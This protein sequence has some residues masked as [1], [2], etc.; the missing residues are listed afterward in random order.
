M[1]HAQW[2]NRQYEFYYQTLDIHYRERRNVRLIMKRMYEGFPYKNIE[3]DNKMISYDVV[4][5][6]L[7][8]ASLSFLYQQIH[9]A[10]CDIIDRHPLNGIVSK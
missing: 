4:E 1:S 6:L 3:L 10:G 5:T 2:R 7:E 8:F 9:G